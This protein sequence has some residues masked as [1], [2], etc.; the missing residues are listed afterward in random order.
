[1]V[2]ER[3]YDVSPVMDNNPFFHKFEIGLPKPVF[4]L[5]WS[6]LILTILIVFMPPLFWKKKLIETEGQLKNIVK[7]AILF[8]MLGLGFMLIEICFIQKFVLFLGYPVLSLA[9]LLSSLLG[10]AS[11]GSIWS[12][13]FAPEKIKRVIVRI[14]LLIVA[15]IVAYAFL[16]PFAFNQLLGLDL[17]IRSLITVLILIPLGFLMGVPFPLGIRW[18]K[19]RRLENQIPWMW[20]VNGVSSVAGSAMAVFV[21]ISLGFTGALLISAGLYLIIFL[22]F[23]KP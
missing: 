9:V 2:K 21:A 15:M 4:L 22:M 3:G 16:L 12:G 10:G 17:T 18:L 20:G 11:L 13:R 23:L 8:S 19:D 6:S 7:S 14:S 1:M 5:F